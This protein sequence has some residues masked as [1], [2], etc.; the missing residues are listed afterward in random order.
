V[1][2]RACFAVKE[3]WVQEVQD[4]ELRNYGGREQELQVTTEIFAA[5]QDF[6]Y[7]KVGRCFMQRDSH[8]VQDSLLKHTR[9]LREVVS[10]V[11]KWNRG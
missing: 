2:F 1:C 10:T 3:D 4:I 11:G 9:L 8:L 5:L 7:L 6:D